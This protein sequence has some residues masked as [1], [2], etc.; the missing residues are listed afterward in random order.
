MY[1]DRVRIG[2]RL[3]IGRQKTV[4]E[5]GEDPFVSKRSAVSHLWQQQQLTM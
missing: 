2:I 3:S 4:I 1:F 5:W